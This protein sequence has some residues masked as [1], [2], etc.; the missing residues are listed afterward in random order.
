M[1]SYHNCTDEDYDEFYP[2]KYQSAGL[3]QALREDPA[4][5]L[6]CLDWND[7]D[8]IEIIGY[9]NDDDYARLEAVIVPCNYVHTMMGHEGDSIHPECIKSL[10][11]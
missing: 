8:P 7:D 6:L 9:E 5:G 11:Q 2:V 4:R 1:L 10:E 3:L